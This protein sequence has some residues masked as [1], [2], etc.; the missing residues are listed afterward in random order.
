MYLFAI[1]YMG[2]VLI[3]IHLYYDTTLKY[4]RSLVATCVP[5]VMVIRVT[6]RLNP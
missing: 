5:S 4:G 6:L 2:P 1:V 3:E